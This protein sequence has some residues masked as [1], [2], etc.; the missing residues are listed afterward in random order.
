MRKFLPLAVLLLLIGG[1]SNLQAQTS[2]FYKY[3]GLTQNQ[4]NPG[5]LNLESDTITHSVAN[6]YEELFSPSQSQAKYSAVRTLP[7][8]WNFAGKNYSKFVVSN[9]GV[10][11]FDTT[12]AGLSASPV[13]LNLP[14]AFM[15]ANSIAAFWENFTFS[16]PQGAD[17]GVYMKVFGVAPNRQIWID[18]FSM[19]LANTT[20]AWFSLVLEETTGKIYMVD[21]N[22]YQGSNFT[23]SVGVKISDVNYAEAPGTPNIGFLQ[24]GTP[25]I[26]DNDYYVFTP[27]S[28]VNIVA[29]LGTDSIKNT[30]TTYP[31][32]YGNTSWG[33][34][35][36]ML[37]LK[38]ELQAIKNTPYL[39]KLALDV[40]SVTGTALTSLEIK[41]KNTSNVLTNTLETGLSTV[42]YN[43]AYTDVAGINEHIFTSPFQWDTTKNLLVEI[44]F[45][46]S[47]A[48]KNAIFNQSATTFPATNIFRANTTS[49]C[50]GTS[51]TQTFNQRPNLRFTSYFD[52]IDLLPPV[53]TY[54]YK[55]I[56]SCF[57]GPRKIVVSATDNKGISLVNCFVDTSGTGTFIPFAM[58]TTGTPNEYAV[59]IPAVSAGK[60][61]SYYV[62][63][64]DTKN[65]VSASE[66]TF[67]YSGNTLYF[68]LGPDKTIAAGTSVSLGVNS[69]AVSGLKISEFMANRAVPGAQTTFPAALNT[70]A[71]DMVELVNI[72]KNT[73]SLAGYK[74]EW[75]GTYN[76]TYTFG[77]QAKIL[78]NEVLILAA[79]TATDVPAQGIFYMQ[80][81]NFDVFRTFEAQGWILR[82]PTNLILDVVATN[83][84]IFAGTTGV[85]ADMWSGAAL[86][87]NAR[88]GGYRVRET[89]TS[90]DFEL[91]GDPPSG[92]SSIGYL[93]P[94]M[95]IDSNSYTWKINGVAFAST[96]MV[97]VAP[98]QTTTYFLTISDGKCTFDDIIT[99]TVLDYC[100]PLVTSSA[101]YISTV[102]LNNFNNNTGWSVNGYSL[103]NTSPISL[104]IGSTMNRL[105][106][107]NSDL[108]SNSRV[109]VWVD[110][111]ADVQF[112][113]NELV[114]DTVIANGDYTGLLAI[115]S[116]TFAAQSRMR[117]RVSGASDL[118]SACDSSV[119]GEVEDYL[120]T[121]IATITDKVAPSISQISQSKNAC[122]PEAHKIDVELTD[123]V[124]VG[125]VTL[126][127]TVSGGVSMQQIMNYDLVANKWSLVIPAQAAAAKVSYFA[128]GTD[129]AGN[130]DTSVLMSYVDAFYSVNAGADTTVLPNTSVTRIVKPSFNPIIIS[131]VLINRQGGGPGGPPAG[132]QTAF[133]TFIPNQNNEV[134]E[135]YNNSSFSVDISGY[136]VQAY[137]AI[138]FVQFNITFPVGTIIPPYQFA[139]VV[140]GNNG[141]N[142]QE[143]V[144]MT[145]TNTNIWGVTERI[146]IVV[147]NSKNEVLD[148]TAFN[149]YTFASTTNVT[150]ADWSGNVTIGN[151]AG[152]YR[153]GKNDSNTAAD[154]ALAN[155]VNG[156][157]S[158]IGTL[159]PGFTPTTMSFKWMQD[160]NFVTTSDTLN[161]TAILSKHYQAHLTVDSCTSI[162]T[163]YLEVDSNLVDLMVADVDVMNAS[164]NLG[165]TENIHTYIKNIGGKN[166]DFTVTPLTV[167][168]TETTIGTIKTQVINTGTL[169]KGDS[170]HVT[171]GTFDLTG[172]SSY[173]TTYGFDVYISMSGDNVP[174]D[175]TVK[176]YA[177]ISQKIQAYAGLDV[178]IAPS[179]S[180]TLNGTSNYVPV[181][182][183]EVMFNRN[184]NGVQTT[185]GTGLPTAPSN[186]DMVEITNYSTLP[187]TLDNYRLVYVSSGGAG[188]TTFTIPNGTTIRAK[189]TLVVVYGGGTTNLAAGVIYTGSANQ[190]PLPTTNPG[191]LVLIQNTILVDALAMNGYQIPAAANV[192][193]IHW[194][195]NINPFVGGSG[196]QLRGMDDNTSKNWV[197]NDS[198]SGVISSIGLINQG[199]IVPTNSIAWRSMSG[200]LID[201]TASITV[202]PATKTDYI[203]EMKQG[204]CSI[205]D[206]VRVTVSSTFVDF[207]ASR[208]EMLTS[209]CNPGT[210]G[211]FRGLVK[212]KGAVNV[213]LATSN[214]NT[215]LSY[216]AQQYTAAV[217][218]GTLNVGDS[219]WVNFNNVDLTNLPSSPLSARITFTVNVANDVDSL[220][221]RTAANFS[222]NRLSVDA[223]NN[224]TV[225]PGTNT[226]LTASSNKSKI[227]ISEVIYN[228][229]NGVVGAQTQASLPF[230]L[231][232]NA[233]SD[234]IELT[235]TGTATVNIGGWI[236]NS[237]GQDAAA[238]FNYTIPTGVTM[239]PGDVAVFV[240]LAGTNDVAKKIFYMGGTI[241]NPFRSVGFY[242]I[243]L[244]NGAV[245]EDV[246]AINGYQFPGTAN[247]TNADWS[248]NSP[249]MTNLCSA[250]RAGSDSNT[251]ADW[252]A[253][254]NTNQSSV[255]ALNKG[256]TLSTLS[257]TWTNPLGTVIGNKASVIVNPTV[258][259]QYHV[260]VNDGTCTATDSVTV[261]VTIAGLVDM[262]ADSLRLDPTI[263][264]EKPTIIQADFLNNGGVTINTYVVGYDVNG[265]NQSIDS[266]KTP[267]LSLQK[268]THTFSTLWQ[269][270]PN[271]TDRVCVWVKATGDMIKANDSLCNSFTTTVKNATN[272]SMSIYPNPSLGQVTVK[273][274]SGDKGAITV[275][276][277]R[278]SIVKEVALPFGIKNADL[279]LSTYSN[280]M[281]LVRILES[282]TITTKKISIYR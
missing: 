149:G 39:S 121:F 20:N 93:N 13:N 106:I 160:A 206:T 207:E 71:Q 225:F 164:C 88:T 9:T 74:L 253:S 61:V 139:Y 282:N 193:A 132:V 28:I 4:G 56:D 35:H 109:R 81:P 42:F 223:G 22:Y 134:V 222:A 157:T 167:V 256:L 165:S 245:N 72:S 216:G 170:L 75:I 68:D 156:I 240:A 24:A 101:Q 6:G 228:L 208:V 51:V 105:H 83:G 244:K 203:F 218:I 187:V 141:A 87:G 12:V 252:F 49:V 281:Y 169:N 186:A 259:T 11:S 238:N 200:S 171:L 265:V 246:V 172:V 151:I 274:L 45:N 103:Q 89:N 168:A 224:V 23:S 86:N 112:A 78:P 196:I 219:L 266:I 41:L 34:K 69:T 176:N 234:V 237:Y 64:V 52:T 120:I 195:G 92:L 54:L 98:L 122:L 276:D 280:G 58:A 210:N 162:D 217:N 247:V 15:P 36:Q 220:N 18:W 163:F 25:A 129:F 113:T 136:R 230:T 251:G 201:S 76:N 128:I 243:V 104:G 250:L 118:Y 2:Y 189:S 273:G 21:R 257:Y 79:G 131:E 153:T 264:Y 82:D 199:V 146:G 37:I 143:R 7:F 235:N 278:G 119:S 174:A 33:A 262:K 17:D 154:W 270:N 91:T 209:V 226:T 96:P 173:P 73:I 213:N 161:V 212:N 111:N 90:S 5:G 263:V 221:D 269:P 26:T 261:N 116:T 159:N 279:D 229:G 236:I 50:A 126:F 32:P 110:F 14:G 185:F 180:A 144:F 8:S 150:A 184:G 179:T 84:Y 47:G 115:P 145:N 147:Y 188:N 227:V 94:S 175:D 114:L 211:S 57:S 67:S 177:V 123:N 248:G 108:T 31:S 272:V 255:L 100:K 239:L 182:I 214:L 40:V 178:I 190:A 166:I 85:T 62:I 271:Q 148:V 152:F 158:T 1:L 66:G 59:V 44:C 181:R 130:A 43:A 204:S 241:N 232:Y 125:N 29:I 38:S 137:G 48:L 233:N 268:Y 275:Y 135:L 53:V 267:I 138:P 77:N 65:N 3:S 249:D 231:P 46:N 191:A 205:S 30:A 102:S 258:T 155:G 117:I 254:S 19:K 142:T 197:V 192:S 80:N 55:P 27:D 198:I 99:L 260:T 70:Q 133:P 242:G 107:K 60:K 10:F 97:S 127:Y 63:A 183:T 95:M 124:T 140:S 16:P 215:R 202:T 194:S 277:L